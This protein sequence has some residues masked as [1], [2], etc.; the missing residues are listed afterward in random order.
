LGNGSS[1]LNKAL[2]LDIRNSGQEKAGSEM[3]LLFFFAVGAIHVDQCCHGLSWLSP[4]HF[5]VKLHK[6][7]QNCSFFLI[8]LAAVQA[9]WA[10]PTRY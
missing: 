9:S 8:K 1:E 10:A 4:A 3:A 7:L 6:L 5:R 2:N